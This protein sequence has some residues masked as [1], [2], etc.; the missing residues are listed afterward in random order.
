MRAAS[1]ADVQ[2]LTLLY[3]LVLLETQW[4]FLHQE[5]EDHS[6]SYST[7]QSTPEQTVMA[8][9]P[10]HI[11]AETV[12]VRLLCFGEEMSAMRI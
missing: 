2:M 8:Q 7:V 4:L 10:Q 6:T 1:S 3:D 5:P 9:T 11:L 12:Q